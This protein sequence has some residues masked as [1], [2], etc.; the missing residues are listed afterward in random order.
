MLLLVVILTGIISLVFFILCLG[1]FIHCKFTKGTCRNKNSLEG[2]T[3]VITG[4]SSGIG[5]ETAKDLAARG[6]KLVMGCRNLSKANSAIK[7]I[8]EATGNTKIELFSLDTSSLQSVEEFAAAVLKSQS[9]VDILILNAG[10]KPTKERC[11]SV[12]GYELL[13]A[14]NHLGHFYLTNLLLPLLETSTP[15]RIIITSSMIHEYVRLDFSD[16]QLNRRYSKLVSYGQ[17]KLMNILHMR[18][19]SERLKGRGVTANALHPGVVRTQILSGDGLSEWVVENVVARFYGKSPLE[20]AQ[21]TIHMATSDKMNGITGLYFTDC[22]P[23]RLG[24]HGASKMAARRM[25]EYSEKLIEQWKAQ[26]R[27]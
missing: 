19:L 5:F 1:L 23:K 3:V 18:E 26:Q 10:I 24:E 6:A 13:L 17:S 20:G 14:T 2:K 8:Q 7:E 16:L 11:E 15:S 9:R 22:H 21:T 4:G 25:W 12:D 27:G